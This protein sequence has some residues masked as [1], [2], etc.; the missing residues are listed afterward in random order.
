[1]KYTVRIVT[2]VKRNFAGK[3]VRKVFE[4]VL[5]ISV[6]PYMAV[7]AIANQRSIFKQLTNLI[8]QIQR[9]GYSLLVFLNSAYHN[10]D[11]RLV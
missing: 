10:H 11:Q 8:L 6:M 4:R 3:A 7:V 5:R 1:M 2:E 9:L